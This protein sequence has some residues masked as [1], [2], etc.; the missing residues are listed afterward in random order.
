MKVVPLVRASASEDAAYCS[1]GQPVRP[2]LSR[3]RLGDK[4]AMATRCRPGV[5]RT[6]DRNI[7]PNLPAPI[8]ST[9]SGLC[10]AA[11]CISIR[12]R[13]MDR[14]SGDEKP[15]YHDTIL[16]AKNLLTAGNSAVPAALLLN[17]SGRLASI[18]HRTA[19]TGVV[20]MHVLLTLSFLFAMALRHTI[21]HALHV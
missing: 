20:A 5:R 3:A 8:N 12:C 7:E 17:A 21:M 1:A 14:D 2:R 11:R 9:R 18:V 13:F 16:D 10:S 6:C 4:S 15:P 19:L